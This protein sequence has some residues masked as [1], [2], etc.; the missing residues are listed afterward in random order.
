MAMQSK[1][2]P[3]LAI[4]PGTRTRTKST[5]DCRRAGVKSASQLQDVSE[6]TGIAIELNRW[7]DILQ[8]R[9]RILEPR[10]REHDHRGRVLFDLSLHHQAEQQRQRRRRRGL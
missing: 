6:C 1:P 7:F 3:M 2:G 5:S 9:I 10:T 4:D 8:G